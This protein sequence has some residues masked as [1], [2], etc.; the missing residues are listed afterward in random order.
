M[1]KE[2]AIN[3][4]QALQRW[5]STPLGRLVAEAERDAMR[6]LLAR[7]GGI[8]LLQLG[9]YGSDVDQ[10]LPFAVRHWIVDREPAPGLSLH[11]SMDDIPLR[12]DSVNVVVLVHAL[13]FAY[14]PH[15]IL[16]E[17]V[18]VLAP[19]GRLLIVGFNPASLWGLNRA[20][21]SLWHG[22]APWGGHYYSSRRLRD[23]C[24]LLD[25]ERL[26]ER[27]LFF[28]PPVQR[29]RLQQRLE[30]LERLGGRWLPWFGGVSIMMSRKR[31]A[32]IIPLGRVL[33]G[34]RRLV[35]GSGTHAGAS[36][37]NNGTNCGHEFHEGRR[38]IQ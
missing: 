6:E 18:R 33:T 7:M 17:A 29:P 19:E 16:R 38:N 5:F 31:V 35:M 4:R 12:D 13:E 34:S 2:N 11:A 20:A 3:D 37:R 26:Q 22:G 36:L 1:A 8:H 21:R 30:R 23:W 24:S 32:R 27:T 25:L 28:R 15:S 10:P 14:E 9:S